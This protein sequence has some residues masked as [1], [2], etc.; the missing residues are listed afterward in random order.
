[1][2]ERKTRMLRVMI[3]DRLHQAIQAEARRLCLNP[4]EVARVAIARGLPLDGQARRE[5]EEATGER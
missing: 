5:R 3:T 1:M 2:R 4:S